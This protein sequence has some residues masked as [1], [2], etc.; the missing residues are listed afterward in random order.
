MGVYEC[1]LAW[2]VTTM[3]RGRVQRPELDVGKGDREM[4]ASEVWLRNW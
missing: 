1:L 2:G 3:S 4:W